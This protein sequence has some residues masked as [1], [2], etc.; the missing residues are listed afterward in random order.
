MAIG[1]CPPT[2]IRGLQAQLDRFANYYNT[3]RPHRSIAR[4]TPIDAFNARTKAHPR[5]ARITVDGYRLRHDK[6][7]RNGKITVRYQGRLHHIGL[8]RRHAGRTVAVL[9]AGPDIR[10]LTNDGR[11]IRELTLDPTRDYQPQN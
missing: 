8:G 11:V 6:I 2:T 5:L 3:I 1:R 4:R 10:V 7:D 9:I